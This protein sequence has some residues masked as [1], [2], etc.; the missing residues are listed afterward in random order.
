MDTVAFKWSGKEFSV[1]VAPQDTVMDL[2]KRIADEINVEPKRQ[3]V[4]GLKSA[5][6]RLAGDEVRVCDVLKPGAKLMVM[7]YVML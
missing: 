6:G 2:K 4:L 7:G 1:S 3:K 5:G